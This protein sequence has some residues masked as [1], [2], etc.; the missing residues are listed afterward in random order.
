MTACNIGSIAFAPS[1]WGQTSSFAPRLFETHCVLQIRW[2]V[3]K[4][5]S[6]ANMLGSVV[7]QGANAD[8]RPLP[9]ACSKRCCLR[10]VILSS[11]P[12]AG[13]TTA[14]NIG[15][16]AFAS[17]FQSLFGFRCVTDIGKLAEQP[18]V[19]RNGFLPLA[20]LFVAFGRLK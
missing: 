8:I 16:I 2:G 4:D 6:G 15:S 20:A 10:S 12:Q 13:D 1:G 9:P 18:L 3:V 17:G 7:D 19:S 11:I 5:I 14:Y